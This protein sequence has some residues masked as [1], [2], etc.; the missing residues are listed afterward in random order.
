MGYDVIL[1]SYIVCISGYF[2]V[3]AGFKTY[4]FIKLV[5]HRLLQAIP[6][7]VITS[8]SPVMCAVA[9]HVTSWCVSANL[10]PD[11]STCQLLS[12]E[13]TDVTS[14]ELAQR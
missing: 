11:T 3:A 2:T 8:S 12:D 1:V 9:C 5:R 13:G 7:D 10:A 6:R 4:V 14:L